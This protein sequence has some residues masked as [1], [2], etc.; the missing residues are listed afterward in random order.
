MHLELRIELIDP[1]ADDGTYQPNK[2]KRV[3]YIIVSIYENK[4]LFVQVLLSHII[5][6]L[7]RNGLYPED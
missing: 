3:D 4:L 6:L 1:E 7:T 5:A 2:V